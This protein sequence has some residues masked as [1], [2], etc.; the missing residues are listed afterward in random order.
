M[1]TE[2]LHFQFP[3]T[4]NLRDELM[5][6]LADAPPATRAAA[7]RAVVDSILHQKFLKGSAEDDWG[8]GRERH[9]PI[10]V[11]DDACSRIRLP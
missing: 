2:P 7:M 9:R 5:A 4:M 6:R 11:S 3:P 8:G 1:E 10:K